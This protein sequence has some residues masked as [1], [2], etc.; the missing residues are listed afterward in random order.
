MAWNTLKAASSSA[1]TGA[2]ALY[3]DRGVTSGVLG[4]SPDWAGG[5]LCPP[6]LLCEPWLTCATAIPQQPSSDPSAANVRNDS[7]HFSRIR[8]SLVEFSFDFVFYF[9]WVNS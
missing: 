4:L 7:F 6:C 3:R 9:Y 5:W 2:G 1:F 8:I